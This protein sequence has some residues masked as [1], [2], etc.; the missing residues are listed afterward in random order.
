MAK[1]LRYQ[2]IMAWERVFLI[3][4]RR[5]CWPNTEL[6]SFCQNWAWTPSHLLLTQCWTLS[7]LVDP[8]QNLIK[9][10]H[11][12]RTMHSILLFTH[13]E[14]EF[15]LNLV[16][17]KDGSMG[18]AGPVFQAWIG[19]S[20]TSCVISGK[21]LNPSGLPFPLGSFTRSTRSFCSHVTWPKGE[22]RDWKQAGCT[23][24]GAHG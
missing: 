1:R 19:D 16:G 22:H 14:P 7:T 3:H 21:S 9:L 20:L 10:I 15:I 8:T 17:Q 2:H 6:W 13:A 12:V 23:S 18:T 11:K 5:Q 24:P 4:E